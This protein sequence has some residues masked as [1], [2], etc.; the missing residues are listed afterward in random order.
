MS[1]DEAV[2]AAV[3]NARLAGHEFSA[4]TQELLRQVASGERTADD[5]VAELLAPYRER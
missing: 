1:P 5:A 3:G 4:E 2:S